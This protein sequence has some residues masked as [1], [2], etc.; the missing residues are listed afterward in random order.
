MPSLEWQVLAKII[1]DG[2]L[3]TAIDAGIAK[4]VFIDLNA[5]AVWDYLQTYYNHITTTGIVPTREMVFERFKKKKDLDIPISEERPPLQALCVDLLRKNLTEQL[6]HIGEEL[7]DFSADPD[8]KLDFLRRRASE[9]TTMRK[10]GTDIDVGMSSD[11]IITDYEFVKANRDGL[12]IPFPWKVLNKETKGMQEGNFIV[13]YGRPKSMK[14]WVL[15]SI[16]AHAYEYA[17]KHVLVYTRE[18]TPKQM[19]DRLMALL[20]KVPYSYFKD[21]RLDEL[22]YPGV[23]GLTYE[24]VFYD[25]LGN[26]SEDENIVFKETGSRRKITI[27]NDRDKSM[28]GSI[29]GLDAK[30]ETYKPDLVLVDGAYLL[31][32]DGAQGNSMRWDEMAY[33]THSLK[34][35]AT[36]HN[37][38]LGATTQANREGEGEGKLGSVADI[39]FSDTFGQDCDL[40]IK[41]VKRQ[42]DRDHNELAMLIAAA[43]EINMEGFA[44]HGNAATNFDSVYRKAL[45]ADNS[46]KSDPETGKDIW[47]PVVFYNRKDVKN[48]FKEDSKA[49]KDAHVFE[50]LVKKSR[51]IQ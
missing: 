1:D 25:M 23:P 16:A 15:L 33:I 18:M 48:M 35:I 32:R 49:D 40:A 22:P 28:G 47:E 19:R 5:K 20:L 26:M 17:N 9:L 45:N 13:L 24:D 6:E 7:L 50:E 11:Q 31:H 14:T 38:P 4:C 39:A 46:V 27:T 36:K 51:H 30:V 41:V 34:N 10:A 44:I 21:S 43:R 12:G 29:T 37:I 8:V 2:D 3:R 42:I